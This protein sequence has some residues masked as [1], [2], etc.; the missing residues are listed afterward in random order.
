MKNILFNT[1]DSVLRVINKTKVIIYNYHN[2]VDISQN[3]IA[4]EKYIIEGND[5]IVKKMDEFEIEIIGNV[6]AITLL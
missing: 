4:L 1:S 3:K 5:L 2:V 6:E